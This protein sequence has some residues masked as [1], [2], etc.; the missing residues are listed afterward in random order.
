MPY[1]DF[2][3]FRIFFIL[4]Y[5][6]N[7]RLLYTVYFIHAFMLKIKGDQLAILSRNHSKLTNRNTCTCVPHK[8]SVVTIV[9]LILCCD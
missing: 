4:F 3:D 7:P 8:Y 1:P 2:L 9:Y 5:T 6:L